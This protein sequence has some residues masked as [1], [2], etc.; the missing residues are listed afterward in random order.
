MSDEMLYGTVKIGWGIS[1]KHA[2]VPDGDADL[3]KKQIA[4]LLER[5]EEAVSAALPSMHV[6]VALDFD[7]EKGEQGEWVRVHFDLGA[8][9]YEIDDGP[10]NGDFDSLRRNGNEG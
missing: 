9:E 2:Q 6:D 7:P 1:E 8:S 5:I 4:A 3:T 10:I